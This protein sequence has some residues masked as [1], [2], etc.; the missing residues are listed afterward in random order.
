MPDNISAVASR[1]Y[2]E[3]LISEEVYVNIS[4]SS[5]T[6]RDKALSLLRALKATISIRPQLLRT[7]I[8]VLK[9]DDALKV[10]ADKMDLELSLHS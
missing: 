8:K 4:S 3:N 9:R 7:L 10:I 5:R 6:G 1:L 2:S